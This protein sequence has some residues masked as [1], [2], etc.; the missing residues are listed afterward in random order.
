MSFTQ[1]MQGGQPP[2]QPQQGQNLAGMAKQAAMACGQLIQ[3]MHAVPSIDPHQLEQAAA[4][5]RASLMAVAEIA[6]AAGQQPGQ[7]GQP[8]PGAP[9]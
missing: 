7:Q 6:K 2:Q 4:Q 3:A 8:Q 9:M 1:A 5:L